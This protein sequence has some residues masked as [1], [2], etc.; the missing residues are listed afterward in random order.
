MSLVGSLSFVC[1]FSNLLFPTS[2]F[3]LFLLLSFHSFLTS[4]PTSSAFSFSTSFLTVLSLSSCFSYPSS[5]IS[6][7]LHPLSYSPLPFGSFSPLRCS[8]PPLP[9]LSPLSFIR[10][11]ILHFLCDPSLPFIALILPFLSYR[12]SHSSAFLF[13][14][15]YPT[16]LSLLSLFSS[17]SFLSSLSFIR[18]LILCFLSDSSLF[19]SLFFCSFLTLLVPSYAFL[20]STSF[21]TLLSP[22]LL[23]S[24]SSLISSLLHPLSHSPLPF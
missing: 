17:L 8:S 3:C 1:P 7:R 12:L 10:F 13:S 2:I 5:L 14:T 6:S 9:L 23:F 18:F 24:L 22:S 19:H 15:S 20:F 16:L 4:L 11:L 21:L